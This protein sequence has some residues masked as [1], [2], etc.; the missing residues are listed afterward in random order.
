MKNKKKVL[1]VLLVIAALSLVIA[2][3]AFADVTTNVQNS[4]TKIFAFFKGISWYIYGVLLIILFFVKQ[5]A[6]GQGN[7]AGEQKAK[8]GLWG[9]TILQVGIFWGQDIWETIKGWF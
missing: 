3:A 7:D 6:H 9:I 4:Q 2:P 1:A 5:A 8:A